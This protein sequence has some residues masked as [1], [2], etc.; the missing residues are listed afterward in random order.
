MTAQISKSVSKNYTRRDKG[1]IGRNKRKEDTL[2]APKWKRE[3][4]IGRKKVVYL[5]KPRV[6]GV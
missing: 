2:R 3:R 5:F 6:Q 4:E 1:A